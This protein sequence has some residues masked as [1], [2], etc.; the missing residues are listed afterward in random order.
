[1]NVVVVARAPVAGQCKT[2]MIPLLG[3]RGAAELQAAL[4]RVTLAQLPTG[5]RVATSGD[6]VEAQGRPTFAQEGEHLGARL[7]HA[8]RTVG[9]PACV[10]GT[11]L[12]G[13]RNSDFAAA[14]HLLATPG[15]DVVFG[16]ATDGGWWLGAFE[17]DRAAA[18]A[19]GIEP[20]LWGGPGVLRACVEAA[21]AV[22]G[23]C[24]LLDDARPDLDEPGDARAAL[25]DPATPTEIRDV[26][27]RWSKARRG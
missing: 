2:R 22:G 10:V 19:L 3:A 15:V 11:D 26:L 13:L 16:P 9:F 12:P 21:E 23:S 5:A 7:L 24:V 4:T 17:N 27:S 18:A 6:G 25:D 20:T 14:E 8:V 1:M